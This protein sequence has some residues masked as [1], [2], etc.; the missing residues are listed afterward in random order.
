MLSPL[1]G[2]A[3]RPSLQRGR[4][5][6]LCAVSLA[7]TVSFT[8]AKPGPNQN[9]GDRVITAEQFGRVVAIS[10]DQRFVIPR[11]LD[12]DDWQVDFAAE[13]LELLNPPERRRSPGPNGWRFHA[14]RIGETDVALTERPPRGSGGPPAPRRFVVTIRVTQRGQR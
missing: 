8:T 13:I 9:D 4:L 7:C 12:V 1:G 10:L 14:I 11:P 5:A 6:L 3:A 2:Q